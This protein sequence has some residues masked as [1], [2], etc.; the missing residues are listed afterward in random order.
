MKLI[1]IDD[2]L[3]CPQNSYYTLT[4]VIF[5]NFDIVY[6]LVFTCQES[7]K[8]MTFKTICHSCSHEKS[9]ARTN[10]I[11]E[12]LHALLTECTETEREENIHSTESEED[13]AK[14]C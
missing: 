9:G 12:K 4:K 6:L 10:K 13:N 3:K 2:F 1:I 14:V 8:F 5:I 7:L 11:T